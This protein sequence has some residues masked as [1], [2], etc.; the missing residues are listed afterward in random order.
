MAHETLTFRPSKPNK[1]MLVEL[2]KL[3]EQDN[4]NLNN[5][6]ENVLLNH[7]KVRGAKI[8]K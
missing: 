6:I 5:Y 4:R 1:N 7:L 3:A 2:N 8:K